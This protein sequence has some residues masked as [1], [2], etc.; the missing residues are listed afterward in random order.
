ME[1]IVN[2]LCFRWTQKYLHDS[3]E[4]SDAWLACNLGLIK[5]SDIKHESELDPT[6][7]HLQKED[8]SLLMS[9]GGTLVQ[10]LRITLI[11]F[12]SYPVFLLSSFYVS[13]MYCIINIEIGD[14]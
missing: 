5:S 14:S 10:V 3:A 2:S 1:A 13:L 7:Q 8:G 4:T 11:I 6:I 9:I 12:S